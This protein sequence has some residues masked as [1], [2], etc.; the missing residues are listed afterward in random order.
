VTYV[1]DASAV[2]AFIHRER[3]ADRV[4][5]ALPAA[6]IS[7]VNLAEVVTKLVERGTGGDQVDRLLDRLGLDVVPFD[8]DMACAAGQ[9]RKVTRPF[10]LSLGDRA[11]LALAQ[12]LGAIALTADRVWSRLDIAVTIELVR[13]WPIAELRGS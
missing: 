13:P 12:H 2:M 5:V 8:R 3:G 4:A 7:A 11:C 6:V 10:G 9:L 1:L